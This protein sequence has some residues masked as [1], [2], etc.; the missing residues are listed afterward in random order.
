MAYANQI[1]NNISWLFLNKAVNV[2]TGL[3]SSVIVI[4]YIGP[5]NNGILSYSISFCSLF[6]SLATMGT[7]DFITK[8]FAAEKE[9]SGL[10]AGTSLLMVAVGGIS[11]FVLCNLSVLFLGL[12]VYKN[13]IFILSFQFLFQPLV[14]L[15]YWFIGRS[16]IKYFSITQF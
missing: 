3:V 9:D 1:V 6:S 11:S 2:L 13:Y 15:Q 8:E 4:K 16:K 12:E 7:S 10:V 14:I 5:T